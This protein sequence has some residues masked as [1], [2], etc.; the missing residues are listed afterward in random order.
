MRNLLI[1]GALL[2]SLG[3]YSQRV[4]DLASHDFSLSLGQTL[5]AVADDHP[6][7]LAKYRDIVEGSPFFKDQWMKGLVLFREGK[8][9]ARVPIRLNIL[10]NEVDYKNAKGQE[11]V[12]TASLKQVIL[13]DSVSG[14]E[15]TFVAGS[16]WR[17]D[18]KDLDNTW[19][20][21]L[22]NDKVSLLRLIRKK[23][24]TSSPGYGTNTTERSIVTDESY[25][26]QMNDHLNRVKKWDDL[27]DLFKDQK[28]AIAEYIRSNKL[29]GRS[30]EEYRQLVQYYN[31]LPATN[32]I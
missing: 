18:Y 8:A 22:T 29:K 7:S 19:L 28:D 9:F 1:A 27:V 13:T 31:S 24:Q 25:Y 5:I 16:T 3:V 2:S 21:V 17:A 14:E 11:M 32:K 15:F 10:D 30:M 23:V 4:V 12:A 26:V 6:T 20:Q